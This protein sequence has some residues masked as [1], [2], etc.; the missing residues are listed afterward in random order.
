MSTMIAT[1]TVYPI[2]YSTLG[3]QE[4]IDG[5]MSSPQTLLIDTRISP[6]SWNAEWSKDALQEKYGDRY[7][8][9]GRY[10]GN[11]ALRTGRIA[12]ANP[13][14]GIK[15]LI[16]YLNEGHD[17]VLLC[18]CRQFLNCHMSEIVKLLHDKMPEVEVVQQQSDTI[19]CLSIR[20]P[21]AWL[22][23]NGFKNIENRDWPTDYRGPL[24]IHAGKAFDEDCFTRTTIDLD[25]FDR[26]GIEVFNSI[27]RC[28]TDYRL[29][30]IIGQA[31]L[32]DVVEKS[33]SRWF[34]G[35]YGFVL[36]NARTIDPIP[37]A[38][39]LKLFDVPRDVV[40][41]APVCSPEG[42]EEALV[43]EIDAEEVVDIAPPDL[44]PGNNAE[45]NKE[46]HN[47][48]VVCGELATVAS[49]SGR[50][51]SIYCETHGHCLRCGSSVEHFVRHP[52]IT[53]YV[54]KCVVQFE[55]QRQRDEDIK[56]AKPVA[57]SF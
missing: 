12:I 9:A 24:L 18:Q 52:Y 21:W 10:L 40:Q 2:G 19:P 57:F 7:R 14:V 29:G 6:K 45:D 35:D 30:C 47:H 32:V 27:P 48:C 49:P 36:E 1:R 53:N 43:V 11:T 42:Q 37:Y 39:K 50:E 38:G 55:M 26:F 44:A 15:G 28:T 41:V 54:C 22:I 31:D 56:Q 17:L 20:Q 13:A 25:L 34:C 33:D 5:L 16:T 8:W 3:S 46:I 4:Y 23:V 51:D